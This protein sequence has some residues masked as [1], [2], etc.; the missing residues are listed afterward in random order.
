M[1]LEAVNLKFRLGDTW[2]SDEWAVLVDDLPVLLDT[3]G[4]R[5]TCQAKRAPDTPVLHE[6]SLDNNGVILGRV[7]VQFAGSEET[8]ET[9]TIRITHSA[10]ISEE[11]DPFSAS[12]EI[13]I[14]RGTGTD[15]ERHTVVAGT[16]TGT[17]DITD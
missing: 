2:A 6:W 5:V 8:E 10:S 15:I 12:F 7:D 1:T 16:I 3:D 13:Q 9:S 14:E 17:E 4:W 11:W